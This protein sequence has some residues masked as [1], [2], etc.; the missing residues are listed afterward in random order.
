MARYTFTLTLGGLSIVLKPP[1]SG[2]Q[3][4]I[5][6]DSQIGLTRFTANGAP[7]FSGYPPASFTRRYSW[8]CS[9]VVTEQEALII[10]AI[11]RAQT[12]AILPVLKDEYYYLEPE[13]T[14]LS[15]GIVSGSGI[16]VSG[17]YISGLFEGNVWVELPEDHKV[18]I[19][20]NSCTFDRTKTYYEINFTMLEVP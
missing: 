15:K 16:T 5:I 20:G 6:T 3:R 13:N 17:T 2:F 18:L 19:G 4:S 12:P 14:T 1:V 9:H 11:A 10:E 7:L 8:A